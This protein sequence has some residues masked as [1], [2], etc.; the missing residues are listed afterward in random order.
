MGEPLTV[1]EVHD[2]GEIKMTVVGPNLRDGQRPQYT[3]PPNVWFGAF[4]TCDIESFT[5]DGSVF[6]KTS[7]RDPALHY[8]F[9]GVTCAPAFQFEDNQLATREDMKALAPKAEAFIN[10]LVPP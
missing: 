7:G 5:E 2:D 8:S 9:V 10:F 6:V 4:L 1:F 3:V